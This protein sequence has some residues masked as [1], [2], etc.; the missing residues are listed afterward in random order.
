MAKRG[1][2]CETCKRGG[3]EKPWLCVACGLE[4]CDWCGWSYGH[5]K[6]CSV[7]QSDRDLAVA[8]NASG[9]WDFEL[10]GL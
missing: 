1:W 9:D 8:A 5:C 4:I 7:G 3:P 10:D 6:A 2:I